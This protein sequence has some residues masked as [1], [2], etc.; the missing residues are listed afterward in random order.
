MDQNNIGF[1]RRET[2]G[3]R[4]AYAFGSACDYHYTTFVGHAVLPPFLSFKLVYTRYFQM[5]QAT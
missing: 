3:H 5:A 2:Q 4:P 1:F